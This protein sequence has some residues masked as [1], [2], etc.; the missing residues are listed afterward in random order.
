MVCLLKSTYKQKLC[1]GNEE[2]KSSTEPSLKHSILENQ[3]T[4][5]LA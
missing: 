5:G 1:C 2:H 4:G 3:G